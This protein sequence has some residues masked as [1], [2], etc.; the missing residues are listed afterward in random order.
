[1]IHHLA[2]TPKN[3]DVSHRFYTE[4]MGFEL[5]KIVKRQAMGGSKAGWTKHVFYETAKGSGSYF[6]L[7]DL[8]LNGVELP[9]DWDPSISVGLGLPW[10]I[11][12]I[13][14]EVKDL[15]ELEEKKQHWLSHGQKVS[16]VVHEFI[17]SIYTRDPD[18]NMV[19]FTTN[20]RPLNDDD[21]AEALELLADDEPASMPDYPGVVYLPD[22][23]IIEAPS[24]E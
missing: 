6:V 18:G 15:T 21:K 9:E 19:E 1:M 8:H 24:S 7:W 10:W 2:I 12:H 5:V 23:R 14:F 17:T 22:G 13:A 4:V 11:N 20:T 3:F 16:E